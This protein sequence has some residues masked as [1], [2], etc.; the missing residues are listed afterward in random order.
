MSQDWKK[1]E[2][3]DEFLKVYLYNRCEDG[4]V[5]NAYYIKGTESFFK[6]GEKD[7]KARIKIT[8][9]EKKEDKNE[10]ERKEQNRL[11]SE[12]LKNI[13]DL[14]TP[15]LIVYLS[16]KHEKHKDSYKELIDN[17]LKGKYS[18]FSY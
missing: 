12:R 15:H 8:A 6:C 13:F 9:E 10:E 16:G 4:E 3:L 18:F 1:Q 17:R 5:W 7:C 14:K 11:V 2:E